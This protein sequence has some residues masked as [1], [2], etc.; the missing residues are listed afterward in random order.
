MYIPLAFNVPDARQLAA[1]IEQNSF[2]TFVS[3]AD[4]RP[5]ASH[6]PLLHDFDGS[7]FGRLVGHMARANPQWQHFADGR[8]V[9]A[10]FHGPHAYVSPRWYTTK[11]AVPTWNYAVVHAYGRPQLISDPAEFEQAMRR[12]VAR[13]EDAGPDAEL[14]AE[15]RS[16]L[17]KAIVGF[18]IPITRLEGKFKLGQNRSAEDVAGVY[19]ELSRSEEAGNRALAEFMKSQGLV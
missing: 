2:A 6:L 15:T 10:I 18:Q 9:L 16:G 13:Y 1:F 14:P 17:M 5:F 4:G 8:E 3:E 11:V 12:I 19:A 7:G